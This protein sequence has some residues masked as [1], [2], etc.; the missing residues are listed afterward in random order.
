M[1]VDLYITLGI[2]DLFNTHIAVSHGNFCSTV[3]VFKL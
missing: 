2:Y 3:L 1:Y